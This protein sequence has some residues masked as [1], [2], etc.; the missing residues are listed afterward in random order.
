MT[1][2]ARVNGGDKDNG[3]PIRG[4]GQAE[5]GLG[6]HHHGR[7]GLPAVQGSPEEEGVGSSGQEGTRDTYEKAGRGKAGLTLRSHHA[8]LNAE[9]YVPPP[10]VEVP[11]TYAGYKRHKPK[12]R[13]L[14]DE[15]VI[16][17]RIEMTSF[18]GFTYAQL[19]ERYNVSTK[20]VWN[21]VKGITFRHLNLA[22]PPLL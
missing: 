5:R 10:P 19:A 13:K 22:F 8:K 2:K 18:G 15:Q 9:G 7:G 20:S 6:D 21:A 12:G 3:G 17:L 11:L 14:T 16:T 1:A 4:V